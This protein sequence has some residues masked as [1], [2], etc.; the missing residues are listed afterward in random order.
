MPE[1]PRNP[2][3]ADTSGADLSLAKAPSNAAF[4]GEGT[5]IGLYRGQWI[6]PALINE[7]LV[8]VGGS[9]FSE[10]LTTKIRLDLNS[11][12][13]E[14]ATWTTTNVEARI[15]EKSQAIATQLAT[16]GINLD[17]ELV[18]TALLVQNKT[19]ALLQVIPDHDPGIDRF[20]KYSKD[21]M[22]PTLSEFRLIVESSG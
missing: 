22:P 12:K 9:I 16:A 19:D 4:R 21:E 20:R 5:A 1:H 7:Q 10:H 13:E 3:T 18:L 14:L 6:E 8:A 15:S 17:P 11:F 2:P